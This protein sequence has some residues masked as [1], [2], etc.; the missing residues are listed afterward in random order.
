MNKVIIG[1]QS[2]DIR[3]YMELTADGYLHFGLASI[4]PYK[5]LSAVQGW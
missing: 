5:W 4:G 2:E 3:P 1:I